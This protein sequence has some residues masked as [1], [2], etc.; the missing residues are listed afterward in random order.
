LAGGKVAEV[1]GAK[2]LRGKLEEVVANSGYKLTDLATEAKISNTVDRCRELAKALLRWWR[3]SGLT[4]DTTEEHLYLP[5]DTLDDG[6]GLWVQG[7]IDLVAVDEEGH[8]V[9]VDWKTA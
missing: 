9:L 6:R 3:R 4:A 1:L 5:L 7:I 2:R 8:L